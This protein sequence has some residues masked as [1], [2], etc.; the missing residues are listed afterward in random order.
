M[1][2]SSQ[3]YGSFERFLV[4]LT[5]RCQA[6]GMRSHLVFHS[7][8]PSQQF[9]SDVVADFHVVP[10]LIGRRAA[11]F[12]SGMVRVLRRTEPT[13]LHAHFGS[14]AYGALALARLRGVRRRF[15]TKHITPRGHEALES[16]LRHR[17]LAAQVE[18]VFAVSERVSGELQSLGLPADKIDVC[19]LGVDGFAY[20][21]DPELRS[22]VRSELGI[23]DRRRVVL[24]TSHLRPNKG[25]HQLPP[26]A[27]AL[28]AEPG[29]TV[30]LAAGDGVL[31][32]QL[33]AVAK[34][35]SLGP[36]SFRLL[37]VREDVPRL[38]AAADLFVLPSE[39]EGTPLAVMEAMASE[40]P[41]VAT[42][43]SDLASLIGG[44]ARLVPPA[45][46]EALVD[47][48]RQTLADPGAAGRAAAGRRHVLE[49]FGV[50][51]AAQRHLERYL[52]EPAA[53]RD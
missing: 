15:Y 17:W 3:Q 45:D 38:L 32:P 50:Q 47:A 25:V 42:S 34:R 19:Y 24:S 1:G 5:Q 30:L 2:W 51:Q 52:G 41:V 16:K 20:R 44:H 29:D 28:A 6:A 35:L 4:D 22:A 43:V 27:A 36:E 12:I 46:L 40:T 8:P 37:G 18:T 48:C 21:P 14:D 33:E 26:L 13:H 11:Q 23:G 7:P 10:P 31:R 49:H 9:V 53:E 39:R